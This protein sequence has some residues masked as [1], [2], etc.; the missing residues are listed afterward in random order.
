MI[1]PLTVKDK[2]RVI[3]IIREPKNEIGEN[4]GFKVEERYYTNW[5]EVVK[6]GWCFKYVENN[7]ILGFVIAGCDNVRVNIYDIEVVEEHRRKGIGSMLL[8]HIL[9]L[10][11]KKLKNGYVSLTTDTHN[12]L[13]IGFYINNKCK[14]LR[15]VNNVM[16]WGD[17]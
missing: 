5:E 17:V 4:Y 8:K 3:A 1:K 15:A 12:Y 14:E 7:N 6:N 13:A 11:N 2:D 10:A 9:K 16:F